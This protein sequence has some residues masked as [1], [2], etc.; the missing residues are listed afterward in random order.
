MERKRENEKGRCA[1]PMT[2]VAKYSVHVRA[3]AG[4]DHSEPG[5]WSLAGPFLPASSGFL[6]SSLWKEKCLG[7]G[8]TS[9][10][11]MGFLTKPLLIRLYAISF[12]DYSRGM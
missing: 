11:I 1:S 8:A 5:A 7:I 9:I 6:D 3:K 12:N 4:W 2:W 10:V